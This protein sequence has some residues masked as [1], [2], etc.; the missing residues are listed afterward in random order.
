ML[1]DYMSSATLVTI[2]IHNSLQDLLQ[3]TSEMGSIQT[4]ASQGYT[5][6]LFEKDC[7][8]S[9]GFTN[10]N[11]LQTDLKDV[12]FLGLITIFNFQQRTQQI[13][14]ECLDEEEIKEF[15]V[16]NK[17]MKNLIFLGQNAPETSDNDGFP[18][19]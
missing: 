19:I 17:L 15:Y 6:T 11:S 2:N 10:G 3:T 14:D 5:E 12:G 13:Y 1:L 18:V 16:E 9:I 4:I 7:S 8:E